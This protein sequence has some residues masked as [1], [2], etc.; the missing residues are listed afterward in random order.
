MLSLNDREWREFKI[1]DVFIVSGSITTKPQQLKQN[2]IVPR[3]TCA[4]NN[5]GID[6]FYKN[7]ATECG[8]VLTVDS[9]TIGSIFYQSV[10][11]IATDHV[12][13][14]SLKSGEMNREVGLFL[15]IAIDK[16]KSNKFDYGYK[17]SQ[18]RIKRQVIKLPINKNGKP[19]FDFMEAFVKE[20]EI[21]KRN[22]YLEYCKKQIGKTRGGY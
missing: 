12:E 18:T 2:G 21:T 10:D 5:N 1:S 17:F 19:D 22:E 6:G 16:S 7:K 8:K 14:L 20:R 11:F 15:K 13:K 4:S 3:I 9:A